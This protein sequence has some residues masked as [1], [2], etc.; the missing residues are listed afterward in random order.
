MSQRRWVWSMLVLAC[1]GGCSSSRYVVQP[2]IGSA[3]TTDLEAEL[4]R[5]DWIKVETRGGGIYNGEFVRVDA[6]IL[7]MDID[8]YNSVQV[9]RLARQGIVSI[10]EKSPHLGHT[11][12]AVTGLACAVYLV[13][14]V[15]IANSL[16]NTAL[17]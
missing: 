6:T 13:L 16:K 9:L 3:T 8:P 2:S 12:L 4:E 10:E 5:G 14:V 15:S 1:L 11:V 7:Y 17:D